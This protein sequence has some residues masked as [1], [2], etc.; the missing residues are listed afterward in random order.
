MLPKNVFVMRMAMVG[1]IILFSAL[2]VMNHA[3][4]LALLKL[5]KKSETKEKSFINPK[6]PLASKIGKWYTEI[7]LVGR[8]AADHEK[9]ECDKDVECDTQ[10]EYSFR[11]ISGAAHIVGPRICWKGKD[12]IWTKVCY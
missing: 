1:L 9:D 8:E 2:T 10:A 5:P 6:D 11:V 3:A 7:E 12:I 4:A